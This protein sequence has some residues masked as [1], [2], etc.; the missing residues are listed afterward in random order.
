MK[1][2]IK[3]LTFDEERSLYN[4][5]NSRVENCVFDGPADGESSFKEARH[6]EVDL[7]RMSLRYPFWHAEDF[8]VTNCTFDEGA[9]AAVWYTK[10]GTL[11]NC[12]LNGIKVFRECD[13]LTVKNCRSVSPEALWKC[14]NFHLED[15]SFDSEYFLFESE[16]GVIENITMKG[17]YSFQY[18]KNVTIRNS[19]LDT[20]DA[21][22][23]AENVTVENCTVKGEY[24]A[25]YSKN[26]TFRNCRIIGT[27]P[28]CYCEGLVLEN[29]TMEDTDLAFEYSH[30]TAEVKGHILSVKNPASGVIKADSIGEIILENSV[31]ENT[32]KIITG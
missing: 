17:K 2:I 9:R 7:C 19:V 25:W 28:L 26:V 4:L 5:T 24:P 22:W 29:C 11:E 21:F 10:R 1:D 20:K 16:N 30:V 6:I 31:V 12:T 13:G 27:Q 18:I 14:R 23:H 15:S 32:C 3:N 8:T